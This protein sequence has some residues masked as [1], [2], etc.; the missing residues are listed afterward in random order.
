MRAPDPS[1]D[2]AVADFTSVAFGLDETGLAEEI[3]IAGNRLAGDWGDRLRRRS[4]MPARLRGAAGS[5]IAYRRRA[6]RMRLGSR[7]VSVLAI[8]GRQWGAPELR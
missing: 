6:R 3:D 1:A 4:P 5:S 8:N 2:G 7:S